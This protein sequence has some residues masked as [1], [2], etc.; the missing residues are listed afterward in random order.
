MHLLASILLLLSISMNLEASPRVAPSPNFQC[1]DPLRAM[2]VCGLRYIDRETTIVW[3]RMAM[4]NEVPQK[5]RQ[6]NCGYTEMFCCDPVETSSLP[7]L[8]N[9]AWEIDVNKS[10][11][12]AK[13]AK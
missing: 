13:I 9:S 11:N 12:P 5:Y 6:W 4:A 2:A 10:C 3:Y 8:P 7:I 1:N